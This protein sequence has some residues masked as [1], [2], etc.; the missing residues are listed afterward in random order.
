MSISEYLIRK[1][2]ILRFNCL[3]QLKNESVV[4]LISGVT[5]A[6]AKNYYLNIHKDNCLTTCYARYNFLESGDSLEISTQM[7]GF[8]LTIG[9]ETSSTFDQSTVSLL[10]RT[11]RAEIAHFTLNRE[12]SKIE[13]VPGSESGYLVRVTYGQP[14]QT[15]P[16]AEHKD[17][18]SPYPSPQKSKLPQ[19]EEKKTEPSEAIF[20]TS[21]C[22]GAG[23]DYIAPDSDN[24]PS[25]EKETLE[26]DIQSIKRQCEDQEKRIEALRQE[27]SQRLQQLEKLKEE[28]NRDYKQYQ[29]DYEELRERLSLDKSI[30]EQYR[31]GNQLMPID[32][33]FLEAETLLD[34][35][36]DQIARFIEARQRETID[37]E[38]ELRK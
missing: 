35:A 37:I 23:S 8:P 26:G 16:T 21:A 4:L 25:C 2:D 27:R 3:S 31:E 5:E 1:K 9:V 7:S 6:G 30:A 17:N 14:P 22:R 19:P 18:P 20:R 13:L 38:E 34:Q 24:A 36:E 29:S 33:L 10:S 11:D 32:R 12:L 15:I 28:Y